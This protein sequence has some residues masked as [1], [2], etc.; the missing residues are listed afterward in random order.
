LLVDIC[1]SPECLAAFTVFE[2]KVLPKEIELKNE[3]W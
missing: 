2:L 3:S 1:V